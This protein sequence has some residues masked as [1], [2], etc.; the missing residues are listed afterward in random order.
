VIAVKAKQGEETQAKATAE[1]HAAE[2]REAK[3]R[4]DADSEV[5]RRQEADQAARKQSPHGPKPNAC[6]KRHKRPRPSRC[7]Q[8]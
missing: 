4:A 5:K 2:E 7:R 8:S 1:K 6:N 3:A